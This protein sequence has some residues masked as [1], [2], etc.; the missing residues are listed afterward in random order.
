MAALPFTALPG[1]TMRWSASALPSRYCCKKHA[2]SQVL[3]LLMLTVE[4][5]HETHAREQHVREGEKPSYP[6][7]DMLN[8]AAAELGRI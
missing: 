4:K 2:S 3:A 5:A 1:D 8:R 6:S 7:H